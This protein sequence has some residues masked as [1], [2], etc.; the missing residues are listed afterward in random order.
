MLAGGCIFLIAYMPNAHAEALMLAM[1]GLFWGGATPT[2]YALLGDIMP[3]SALATAVGAAWYW[4]SCR[5][6]GP[7]CNGLGDQ[8]HRQL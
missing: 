1:G 4:Q 6:A 2:K 5:S 3:P 7:C 8:R